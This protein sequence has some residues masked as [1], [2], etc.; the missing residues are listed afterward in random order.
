M[1]FIRMALLLTMF[2]VF[3]T[4]D[5]SYPGIALKPD[6][7]IS[8]DGDLGEWRVV[9]NPVTMDSPEQVVFGR[10]AWESPSDLSAAAWLAWRQEALF[11]AVDVAD[12][13]VRQTQRGRELWKG[14]CLMLFLDLTPKTDTGRSAFG[15]GQFQIGL[16][17]GDLDSPTASP[18]AFCY[19]P[20]PH[21]LNGVVVAARRTAQGY[22]I[23]ASIPWSTL[24]IDTPVEALPIAFELAVSDTDGDE[25]RQESMITTR[26]DAWEIVRTRLVATALAGTNGR[27]AVAAIPVFEAVQLAQDASQTLTFEVAEIPEGLEAVL[28]LKARM[29]FNV[30]AGYTPSMTLNLNGTSLDIDRLLNKPLRI[31]SRGGALYSMAAGDRLSTFYAP[32]FES[33]DQD[34]HYGLMEGYKACEF[35]LRATEALKPGANT[36]VIANKASVTNALIAAEARIEFRAKSAGAREKKGPPTGDL[37]TIVPAPIGTYAFDAK[38]SAPGEISVTAGDSTLVVKSRFSTPAPAWV[39]GENDFFTHTRVVE[40]QAEWIVVRDTFTNKIDQRLPIMHRHEIVTGDRIKQL[41]LGGLEQPGASGSI[42]NPS[43]PTVCAGLDTGGIGLVPVDDVFHIHAKGYGGDGAIGLADN[44]LVLPPASTYTATW[45]IVP[46]ST[47]TYWGFLNAT[48][49]L[50]DANF[51]IPGGFAFLRNGPLTDEWTDQQVKDFIGFKDPLYVCATIAHPFYNGTYPHGTAFQRIDHE[52]YRV[53]FARWRGFFPDKKYLLYYHCFLDVVEDG[54]ERFADAILR[55]SD[56]R[57]DDYGTPDMKLY[58]PTDTNRYGREVAQNVDV[59]L[60][61]IHADGV[62]W[63]EHEYSRSL[64]HYAEPWDGISGDIDPKTMQVARLKSSVTLLTEKWRVALA[65]R[66]LARG[67]LIGN[68]PPFTRAM[69]ELKFP[70]FV[71]T[72]SITNCTQAHLYSPI[73]LGDHLTERNEVDAYNTMLAALDFG[74]VYHWYNDMTVIPTH[75]TLTSYMFPITPIE[76]HEG[77]II[78]QERIIT[79]RSGKYGWGDLSEHEVHVFDDTGRE[80]T[81]FTAPSTIEANQRLTEIRIGEGWSAAIIR[82]RL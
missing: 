24:G 34:A 58:L 20:D 31:K 14:D 64:Y 22:T 68:G 56:G 6:P 47:N 72:G 32:D 49:R 19:K 39:T 51:L 48:R 41:W 80:T 17:P 42:D 82:K 36:L 28:A 50:L 33:P 27:A 59:I 44:S 43:N 54:P 26:S 13:R 12:D 52:S 77:Y 21:A 40:K 5:T 78:G 8:V 45:A 61:Q 79:N 60:D 23:E 65:K 18:E 35:E 70:C 76:L 74:C 16:S 11:V 30:V 55:A 7:P 66:I 2:A 57:H 69:A 63:D 62:Y 10:S 4:A 15:V 37:A 25:M 9:P 38:E 46:T 75:P 29:E 53:S 3:A 81:E 73:A 1:R 67:P 71:E